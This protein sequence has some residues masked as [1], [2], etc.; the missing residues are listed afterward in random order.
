MKAVVLLSGGIDST[1]C[2]AAAVERYGAD[3]VAALSIYYGQKH[4]KENQRAPF[5]FNNLPS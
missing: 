3:E 1:T 5:F 4:D 2:L